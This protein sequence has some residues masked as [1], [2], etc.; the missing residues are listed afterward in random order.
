MLVLAYTYGGLE[1][2]L[3]NFSYFVGSKLRCVCATGV[4]VEMHLYRL[5]THL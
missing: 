5:K 1:H 2:Q 4:W 3:V